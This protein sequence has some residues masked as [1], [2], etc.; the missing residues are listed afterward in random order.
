[1]KFFKRKK[2]T[3]EDKYKSLS[4]D[5][6]AWALRVQIIVET[7]EHERQRRYQLLDDRNAKHIEVMEKFADAILTMLKADK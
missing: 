7:G 2:C 4:A 5:F 1:M 3:C 6:E